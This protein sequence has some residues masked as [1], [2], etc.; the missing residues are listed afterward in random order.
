MERRQTELQKQNAQPAEEACR[1]RK[2]ADLLPYG[3]L[4]VEV[5]RRA[6]QAETGS[7][8]TEWIGSTGLRAPI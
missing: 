8:A 1:L 6:R 4:R 3:P 2:E 7:H 5:L